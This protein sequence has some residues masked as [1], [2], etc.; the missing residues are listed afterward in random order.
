[1]DKN[2]INQQD[3]KTTIIYR[4][5]TSKK[6]DEKLILKFKNLCKKNGNKFVLSNNIKLAMKLNLDGVYIPA[7]NN[8]LEKYLIKYTI[9]ACI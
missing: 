3:K 2:L 9:L 7:F 1:M 6:I 4:N 5:Y 8:K